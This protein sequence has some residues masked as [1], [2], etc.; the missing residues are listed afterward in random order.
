MS[1]FQ[2]PP[3]YQG[4]RKNSFQSCMGC[5]GLLLVVLLAILLLGTG[6]FDL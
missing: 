5:L 4:P 6:I 1:S 2:G 3:I